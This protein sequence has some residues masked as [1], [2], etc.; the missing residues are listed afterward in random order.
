MQES[1]L[2]TSPITEPLSVY[3]WNRVTGLSVSIY[4]QVILV[5]NPYLPDSEV[6]SKEVLSQPLPPVWSNLNH[7]FHQFHTQLAILIFL[8]LGSVPSPGLCSRYPLC[9]EYTF[10][11]PDSYPLS[12]Q[13]SLPRVLAFFPLAT[14]MFPSSQHHR[15]VSLS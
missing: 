3:A 7:A 5:Y 8:Q 12:C 14:S 11:S 15:L 4:H 2:R 6:L 1:N 10:S 13:L 9:L